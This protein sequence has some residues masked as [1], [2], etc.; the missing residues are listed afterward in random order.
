METSKLIFVIYFCVNILL[1]LILSV[2]VRHTM[3]EPAGIKQFG[4]DIWDQRKIYVPIIV[5]FYDTASDI[6]VVYLWYTLMVD[7]QNGN[8][9]ESVDM[10][11]FFWCGMTFLAL[12]RVV[13][14]VSLVFLACC[15]DDDNDFKWY[16]PILVLLEVY[17]FRTVYMSVK[18]AQPT[19]EFNK[20]TRAKPK[21][22]QAPSESI[23]ET[24]AGVTSD[25]TEEE[26]EEEEM[27]IRVSDAQSY[28]Q[29][30]ESVTES[31]PQ[32]LLQSVFVIRS[33][34]EEQLR[35]DDIW[36]LLLSIFASL[37]SINDK[38][39]SID[40]DNVVDDATSAKF[41]DVSKGLCLNK[42]TMWYLVRVIWRCCHITSTFA[43]Y[44]L[45]WTV[46]GGVWLPIWVSTLCTMYIYIFV[47]IG[48]KPGS[49]FLFSIISTAGI[50]W[51]GGY[52]K[53]HYAKWCMTVIGMVLIA[54]F[55]TTSF[56]CGIC[57]DAAL[58]KFDN[59]DD[60]GVRNYRIII[61]YVVGCVALLVEVSLFQIMQKRNTVFF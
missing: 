51:V 10:E 48:D 44:V 37:L 52:Q 54:V 17:V 58:R 22:P 46:M 32:I 8:D 27:P 26:E 24:Q 1:L 47:L 15:D 21:H 55:A 34:N 49:A 4:K 14:F 57:A 13:L 56:E 18:E 2:Y 7:E 20:V 19:M 53:V 11:V 43:V 41:Q 40:E 12:Y 6:G 38:F 23:T 42:E 31:L 61:F 50:P 59:V 3:G 9:Y 60:D 28:A 36:L 35:A 16:D 29:L 5:H 39:V 30:A 33:Y 25:V 45:I